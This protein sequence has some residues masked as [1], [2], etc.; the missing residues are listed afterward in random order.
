MTKAQEFER[1]TCCL[2]PGT[3]PTEYDAEQ[4]LGWAKANR[5][6]IA[7]A[8]KTQEAFDRGEST[9][10]HAGYY[11]HECDYAAKKLAPQD[12][13]AQGIFRGAFLEGWKA[14]RRF[15]IQDP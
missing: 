9:D 7:R 2:E 3:S 8:L 13:R 12:Q 11:S 6:L 14:A 15:V 5:D 10:D 1:V 4:I